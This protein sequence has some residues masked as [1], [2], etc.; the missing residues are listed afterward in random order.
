MIKITDQLTI[1]QRQK[2]NVI[3]KEIGSYRLAK[4]AGVALSSIDRLSSGWGLPECE[5]KD[6]PCYTHDK[7]C[8]CSNLFSQSRKVQPHTLAK[9]VEYLSTL[10]I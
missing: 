7:E 3:E 6:D 1:E 9:V 2:F 8:L 4:S 10:K 5:V